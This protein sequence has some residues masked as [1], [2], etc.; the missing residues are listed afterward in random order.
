MVIQK[1]GP[2]GRL[3]SSML[4]CCFSPDFWMSE[5]T[6]EQ[7]LFTFPKI[8]PSFFKSFWAPFFKYVGEGWVHASF[9]DYAEKLCAEPVLSIVCYYLYQFAFIGFFSDSKFSYS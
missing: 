4:R 7:N 2:N 9:R 3:A 8:G 1:G 6:L 5:P